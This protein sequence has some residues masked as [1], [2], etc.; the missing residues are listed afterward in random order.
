VRSAAR[1]S[2][3][4]GLDPLEVLDADRL[5]WTIRAACSLAAAEE[6]DAARRR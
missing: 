4:F 2:L 5:D 3:L 6:L 1:V